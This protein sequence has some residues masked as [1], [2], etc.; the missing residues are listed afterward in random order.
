MGV[1]VLMVAEKPSLAS[2]IAQFLSNGQVSARAPC[3]FSPSCRKNH[4]QH[5]ILPAW[6]L[7]PCSNRQLSS[8]RGALDV[9]EW[10]GN[11][12]GE[13]AAFKMTSVIGRC[14]G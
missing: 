6:P 8:R 3:P 9:H 13:P 10:R 7:L 5:C 2:S 14:E 11:F 12:R 1:S 4:T